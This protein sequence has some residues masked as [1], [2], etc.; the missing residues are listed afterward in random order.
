MERMVK[1]REEKVK[2]EI[3]I[4]SCEKKVSCSEKNPKKSKTER[5]MTFQIYKMYSI[6][7]NP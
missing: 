6:K 1:G 4:F 5:L 7:R 2:I 3:E